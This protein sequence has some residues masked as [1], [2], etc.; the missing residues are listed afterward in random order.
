MSATT[1]GNRMTQAA[2]EAT[3][4]RE[5]A[6]IAGTER[7]LVALDFDG[8]LAPLRDEPMDSRALPESAAAIERLVDAPDTV[9]ALVSGRTIADLRV[10]AEHGEDARVWLAGSHGVE[11]WRPAGAAVPVSEGAA[12]GDQAALAESLRVRA[13]G[14]VA[15]IDGAWIEAK[16]VGF[17]LHTRMAAADAANRAHEAVSALMAAEA[18]GWRRREGKD[19]AEY[20]WR[21]EGKEVA[22]DTL[23]A[24]TR[25]TAVLFAGDDVTDEDALAR[26]SPGDLG[27]RVG[28]GATHAQVRVADAYEFAVLLHRLADLRAP[29]A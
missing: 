13:D 24:E 15:G 17:A 10:I 22:I 27:V 26:L 21:H 12:D 3:A 7:L 14:L 11:F 25:A 9:V 5:L 16:A 20:T 28:E 4:E 18:P 23:R 19:L 6:R 8:T 29:L 2:V 1:E